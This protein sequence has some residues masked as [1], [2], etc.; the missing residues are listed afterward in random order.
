MSDPTLVESTQRFYDTVAR[1]NPNQ[2]FLN[3]GFADLDVPS[4]EGPT[5]LASV[6]RRLY[7]E[8]LLPFPD[9]E[10]VLEVGCG[11]GGGA[12]FLLDQRPSLHYLGL[13]LSGEHIAVCRRRFA[14]RGA[15]ASFAVANAS[16]LPVRE[17][18]FDV[19]FSVEAVHHFD[20][21]LGFYRHV[22]RALRPGGW[23]LLTG[24]WRP[25]VDAEALFGPV[26]FRVVEHR[27]ITAN[28]VASLTRTSDLR[29][30]LIASLDLPERFQPLLMSWAGVRGYGAY[31]SLASGALQY[32]RFRLQRA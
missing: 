7:Q 15:A 21:P 5:D 2:A 32:L 14:S 17:A 19:A 18:R 10:R 8:V 24:L 9:A 27:D 28:V 12:A 29:Q 4:G 1:Q 13:D 25:G 20:D 30:A 11:R 23:F 6:C 26:G 31:D 16:E 3:Y 22:A